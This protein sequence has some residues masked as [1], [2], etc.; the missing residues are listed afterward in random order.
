MSLPPFSLSWLFI[1]RPAPPRLPKNTS[2]NLHTKLEGFLRNT[3]I[4]S[5][6]LHSES[7]VSKYLQFP[8]LDA[9]PFKIKYRRLPFLFV[10]S[11]QNGPSEAQN[12]QFCNN[13]KSGKNPDN[14]CMYKGAHL[15][16]F[17]TLINPQEK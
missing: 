14:Y 8:I 9:R 4:A 7:S 11:P 13:I 10:F 1:V 15:N 12:L 3:L 5:V 6:N 17:I 16:I 2:E